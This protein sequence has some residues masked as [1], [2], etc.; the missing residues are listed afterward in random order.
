M[1]IDVHVTVNTSGWENWN[2][3][4]YERAYLVIWRHIRFTSKLIRNEFSLKWANIIDKY[5]K[6]FIQANQQIVFSLTTSVELI[7]F[8][9]FL[10]INS[11]GWMH[12]THTQTCQPQ[13]CRLNISPLHA[14]L[15]LIHSQSWT[16]FVEY[17][18]WEINFHIVGERRTSRNY[19]GKVH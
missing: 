18:V 3:W 5:Y 14:L 6:P 15:R 11:P 16:K 8:I 1:F 9:S 4:C 7:T 17:F 2:D 19:M 10:H 12:K 13:K